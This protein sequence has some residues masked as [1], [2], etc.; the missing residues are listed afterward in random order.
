[1]EHPGY[2]DTVKKYE[3]LRGGNLPP[4]TALQGLTADNKDKIVVLDDDPT[5]VQAVHDVAVYTDWSEESILRG[6]ARPEK[7]FF[8]LTNSRAMTEAETVRV[9]REI[10]ENVTAAAKKAGKGFIII[11]R[12]D[13]TLR[14][15][16]PAE[17]AALEERLTE[18]GMKA[19]DGEILIPFFS[20]GGRFT[21]GNVHYV[22]YG[23]ELVPAG[24][25]EF[26]ADETF[27]YKNSDL[28]AY[29]EEKT[30]GRVKKES[31]TA[32]TLEE[33]RKNDIDGIYQKLMGVHDFGKVIVNALDAGDLT[34]FC[35]AL[36]EAIQAGRHFQMRTAAD[37]VKVFAGIADRPLLRRT[38]MCAADA[39][40]CGG[41]T[42]IGSHTAKTT[43]QLAELQGME[44]LEMTAFD[45]DLVLSGG[46]ED[47]ARRVAAAAGAAIKAG[48]TAVVYTKRQLLKLEGDTKEAALKRSVR[49]SEAV[50]SMVEQIDGKPAFIIAKGGIT[51]SDIGVKALG[52]R[53]AYVLGQIQPGIPVWRTDDTSR[54]PG[55]PYVIFPG[56]VGEKDTL[57][58]V[59]EVLE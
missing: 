58:K 45:S 34:V 35:V 19:A 29:I 6:F 36:Y 11:S 57:K 17:T 12:A 44:G 3:R 40:K 23:D 56:N 59:L 53:E 55:I 15:H 38:E 10:A 50:C 21:V 24:E 47:E 28:C 32:V 43:A 26:A 5:G 41:L 46:L 30:G 14:G 51:S 13:S 20:A 7:A 1:M 54:F 42:V 4:D 18:C 16:F 31:V 9:H 8:I 2:S 39:K 52:V 49:I 48:R 37:F 33:L 22:R 27:G 25:T